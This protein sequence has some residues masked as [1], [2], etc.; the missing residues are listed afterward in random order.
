MILILI[1]ILFRRSAQKDPI[2]LTLNGRKGGKEND[3]TKEEENKGER[4]AEETRRRNVGNI[5][6]PVEGDAKVDGHKGVG[7]DPDHRAQTKGCQSDSHRRCREIDK[8]VGHEGRQ[9]KEKDVIE[10]VFAM[11]L[12]LFSQPLESLREDRLESVLEDELR[13]RERARG[14]HRG[15]L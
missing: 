9:T 6:D 7:D 14:S 10:E 5:L 3:K 12:H 8:P 15:E 4:G 11:F 1:L 2:D 13:E